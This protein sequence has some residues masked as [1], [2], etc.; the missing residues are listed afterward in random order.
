MKLKE[1]VALPDDSITFP[2]YL[3]Q[4]VKM[5]DFSKAKTETSKG[6]SMVSS[7]RNNDTSVKRSEENA[8]I[9]EV[10]VRAVVSILSG[11]IGRFLKD[12]SFRKSVKEKINN[13]LVRRKDCDDGGVLTDMEIGIESIERL[14]EDEG[15]T[16]ME[17]RMKL[18]NNSIQLLSIVASLNS[19]NSRQ[20]STCGIPNAHLSA[21]AQLYM[22]II[23]K[24]EKNDRVCARHLLQV[25]VDSPFFVRTHLLPD[26]WE[27][28]FLP[29]L[30]HLKVWYNE[31]LESVSN[32]HCNDKEKRMKGLSK[33][34]NE[35]M[36]MGTTKFALYY[37]QWLKVGANAPTIP[38]VPLPSRSSYEGS[39]SR[40]RLSSDSLTS[41]SSSMNKNL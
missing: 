17:L 27:H 36:D 40:R 14:V 7:G 28:I 35:Q 11:Y 21:L 2:L 41:E 26:L 25:F 33:V 1:R 5:V 32:L 16:N 24:M 13:V 12:E 20:N 10:A 39:S 29:H 6:S 38:S 15:A 37:K 3:C 19:K 9:D 23:Y 30:L 34:Y 31:Q 8:P 4:N 22:A 18:L